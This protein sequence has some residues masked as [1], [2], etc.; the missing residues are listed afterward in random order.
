MDTNFLL[1]PYQFK[2]NIFINLEELI[3]GPHSFIIPSGVVRELKGLS[4]GKGKEGAAARFA[5]KL[6][7]VEKPEEI[8]SNGN[9]DDWIVEYSKKNNVIVATND[10][11]LR[12]R[13]KKNRVK[14]ISLLSRSRMGVV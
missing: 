7:A 12:S 13:L 5:L 6:I 1:V 8:E 4:S 11:I 9:V 3:E 10:R 2:L 14:V